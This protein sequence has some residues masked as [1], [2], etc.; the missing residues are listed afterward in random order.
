MEATILN[1]QK[2]KCYITT[3]Q[4]LPHQICSNE[5]STHFRPGGANNFL[6]FPENILHTYTKYTHITGTKLSCTNQTGSRRFI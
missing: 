6:R 4:I 2:K 1:T 5:C 3:I